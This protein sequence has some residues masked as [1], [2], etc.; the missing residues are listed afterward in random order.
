VLA[1]KD[2]REDAFA[3]ARSAIL[4]CCARRDGPGPGHP[5]R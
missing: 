3:A 4:D 5:A 1:V 2:E